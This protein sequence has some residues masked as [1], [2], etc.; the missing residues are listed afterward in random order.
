MFTVFVFALFGAIANR[1]SGWSNQSWIPG[2]HIYWAALGLFLISIGTLGLPWAAAIAVSALTYRIPGWYHSLDMGTFAD[3]VERDAKIM[4]L[5][6]LRIAPVFVYALVV[7]V[8]AAPFLLLAAAGGTVAIYY[9]TNHY[10]VKY[11]QDPFRYG[12]PLVGALLGTLIGTA[13]VLA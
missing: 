8:W 10:L 9:I 12:E 1:F 3:S 5:N 4:F 2:R 13:Y 11:D 6:T 7:G